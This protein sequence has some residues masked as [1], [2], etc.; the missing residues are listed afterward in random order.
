MAGEVD[1]GY[2]VHALGGDAGDSLGEVGAIV[3]EGVAGAELQGLADLLVVV[4]DGQ[5]AGAIA[6]GEL[7]GD[8]ADPAGG[9]VDEHGEAADGPVSE[10]GT[11]GGDAG[12]S[13]AGGLRVKV[14]RGVRRV[15]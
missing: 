14:V 9:S 3:A 13:Q 2:P 15:G 1:F 5:D 10:H 12:D 8:G 7:G 4:Y 6:S 11:V